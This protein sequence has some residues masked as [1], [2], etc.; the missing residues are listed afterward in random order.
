MSTPITKFAA[1]SF[2]ITTGNDNVTDEA[3]ILPVGP[4]RATDG[5]P[6]DAEAWQ[7]DAGIAARVISR[8]SAIKNDLMIDY[9]HQSLRSKDNGKPVIA[10][11]WFHDL[12]WRD[13][14][15][16]YA[17]G[18]G[19][20]GKAKAHILAKEIRYISAVFTYYEHTGEV[21][22]IISIT[23][24]NTP[25]LDGLDSLDDQELAALSKRFSLPTTNPEIDMQDQTQLAAL[26]VERDGLTNKVA[27]LTIERDSLS[28]QVA[29][30]TTE[31]DTLKIR[32]DAFDAEK[33]QAALT[34]DKAR[35]TELLTAALTDGRLPPALKDWAE[36]R[37]LADLTEYLQGVNPL[38][39]LTKQTTDGR[40]TQ[41]AAL[42]SVEL[43][44]IAKTGISQE[45]F[46]AQKSAK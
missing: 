35:H 33:V 23:L 20:T 40:T 21:V 8:L 10:A 1:L 41:T 12:E 14:L 37:S 25:A 45:D 22:E 31:R 26:T 7:L 13:S 28:T 32:V 6:V 27:A 30:L 43:D 9:E 11:G 29:A 4:F 15:G 24:T 18:I 17:T 2:E 5:R 3:H 16:L 36:K 46:L 42:T 19:W 38:A 39:M 44:V 34:A